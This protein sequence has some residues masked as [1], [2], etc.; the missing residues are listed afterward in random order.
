MAIIL[1]LFAGIF[2]LIFLIKKN[3]SDD[4]TI[5]YTTTKNSRNPNSSYNK[6]DIVKFDIV[7]TYFRN[8]SPKESGNFTGYIVAEKNNVHDKYAVA[9]YKSNHV[10]IG[11]VPRGNQKLHNTLVKEHNGKVFAWGYIHNYGE[12]WEGDVCVPIAY[13]NQELQSIKNIFDLSANIIAKLK[14]D[15]LIKED[16][17][18][19]LEEDSKQLKLMS[20][21]N[22]LEIKSTLPYNFM[23]HSNKILPNL[24]K[25]LFDNKDWEGFI[26]LEKYNVLINNMTNERSKNALLKRIDKAKEKT[27]T[28]LDK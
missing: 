20:E 7:G 5:S 14:K 22:E 18:N 10:H 3:K 9:V 27:Q 19:I 2:L 28:T 11:Y 25:L 26:Y 13:N 6:K 4:A 1:F 23:N 15:N 12:N 16:Y 8:I 17:F 21:F 24:S